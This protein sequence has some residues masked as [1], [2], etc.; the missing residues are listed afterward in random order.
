[1]SRVPFLLPI[2]LLALFGITLWGNTKPAPNRGNTTAVPLKSTLQ[3]NSY[4][5]KDGEKADA[6]ITFTS[7]KSGESLGISLFDDGGELRIRDQ[8]AAGWQFKGERYRYLWDEHLDL[9]GWAAARPD[10]PPGYD[11]GIRYSPVRTL[12]GVLA[13]DLLIGSRSAGVGA[14][15]YIP[16]GIVP[17]DWGRLGLGIGYLVDYGGASDGLAGYLTFSTRY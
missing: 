10:C 1:V 8:D 5:T 4:D 7:R 2:V 12:Y 9:G 13:P 11:L 17:R 16:P 15:A 3:W 6:A 14:S